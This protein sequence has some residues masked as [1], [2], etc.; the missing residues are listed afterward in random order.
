MLDLLLRLNHK[1]YKEEEEQGLHEK[2]GR[3]GKRTTREGRDAEAASELLTSARR[4]LGIRNVRPQRVLSKKCV[5]TSKRCRA[6]HS[7]KSSVGA[8]YDQ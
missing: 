6:F 8:S 7:I 2:G 5:A 4:D 1:R 3:R